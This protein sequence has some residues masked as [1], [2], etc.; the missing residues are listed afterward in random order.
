MAKLII[1][2]F[3]LIILIVNNINKIEDEYIWI[4]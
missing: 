1:K 4:K 2:W 3:I